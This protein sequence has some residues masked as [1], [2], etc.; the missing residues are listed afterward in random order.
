MG[1]YNVFVGMDVHARSITAQA[2]IVD[3]VTGEKIKELYKRFSG[4]YCAGDI[5]SWVLGLGDRPYCAYESGCTGV[6]LAQQLRELGIE[7]DVIAISTL[8]RSTK[9]KQVKCDKLDARAIL[10]EIT[11]QD[12][13]Y[14]CVYIPTKTEEGRRELVRTYVQAKD[15]AK[16]AS[17][18]LSSFLLRQS[19]VWNEKTPSGNLKKTTGR[20]YEAWLSKITFENEDIKQAFNIL[21]RRRD[22]A[23]DEFDQA[24]QM[25]KELA[26][27]ADNYPFVV[28]L[29]GLLGI[30]TL[31]AMVALGEFCNFNRFA[32]GRAVSCW[33]GTVPSNS[34][35]GEK[36]AHGS[37]TKSGDKYLRK[38]LI[39][40]VCGIAAW[41][42]I[43]KRSRTKVSTKDPDL[44]A[45][46]RKANTRLRD[47]YHHL[48]QESKKNANKAKV[49]IA[50]ELV[51]WCW[52]IGQKVQAS[53]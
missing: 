52:I 1:K 7:C 50:N 29:T 51:R 14:S 20:A 4:K 8:P 9:D 47:R 49:A 12:P 3:E 34:S 6:V 38:T 24:K 44:E 53:L 25:M 40:S 2:R 23:Y 37:I 30:D 19:Y 48:T 35:S 17:Q 22:L 45:L 13:R 5:A 41:K 42:N 26:K 15:S 46:I 21:R 36:D 10:G 43:S 11:N 27:R 18:R 32:K 39:E 31:S 16:Q 33:L 28:A